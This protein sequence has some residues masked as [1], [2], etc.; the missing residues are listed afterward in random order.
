MYFVETIW[1]SDCDIPRAHHVIGECL[2]P[3]VKV[4]GL[5]PGTRLTIDGFR[6]V[7][8]AL[9]HAL[10]DLNVAV[11]DV[12]AENELVW[13]KYVKLGRFTGAGGLYGFAPTGMKARRVG[14]ESGEGMRS[15]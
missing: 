11:Y 13:L 2:D 8:D 10:P 3:N 6:R 9:K 4:S 12:V 5:L 1:S 15:C 14:E 7:Y